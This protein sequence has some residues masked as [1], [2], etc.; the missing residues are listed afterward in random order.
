MDVGLPR[1]IEFGPIEVVHYLLSISDHASAATVKEGGGDEFIAFLTASKTGM[2]LPCIWNCST[3]FSQS[4]LSYSEIEETKA[5][6]T[7]SKKVKFGSL[8]RVCIIVTKALFTTL[9]T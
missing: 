1:P 8:V 7:T 4:N 9:C 6:D 2:D 5:D 3:S